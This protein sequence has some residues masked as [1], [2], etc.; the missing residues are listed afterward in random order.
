[1]TDQV[2][3]ASEK[4]FLGATMAFGA[5]FLA[6]LFACFCFICVDDEK[7]RFGIQK[8]RRPFARAAGMDRD[9]Q[10]TMA[11]AQGTARCM[12]AWKESKEGHD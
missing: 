3:V 12:A 8:W 7:R 1:M 10:T 5:D 6:L 4:A 2:L 11:R 9:P